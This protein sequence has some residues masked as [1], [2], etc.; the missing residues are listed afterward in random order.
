MEDTYRP[1]PRLKRHTS[2]APHASSFSFYCTLVLRSLHFTFTVP[3]LPLEMLLLL[4]VGEGRVLAP[5]RCQLP[6]RSMDFLAAFASNGALYVARECPL[7]GSLVGFRRPGGG[8]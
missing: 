4:Q 3:S 8:S 7:L 5:R 2:C 1:I 6:V